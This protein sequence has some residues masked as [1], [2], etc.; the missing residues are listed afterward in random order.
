MEI[1]E[2]KLTAD[3]Q[4]LIQASIRMVLDDYSKAVC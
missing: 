4:A 2:G 1:R 3:P